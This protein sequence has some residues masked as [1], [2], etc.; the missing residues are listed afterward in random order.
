MRNFAPPFGLGGPKLVQVAGATTL[1]WKSVQA[2]Q[3]T[4]PAG[5]P[6]RKASPVRTIWSRDGKVTP[7]ATSPSVAPRKPAAAAPPPQPAANPADAASAPPAAASSTDETPALPQFKI[8]PREP[9]PSKLG[10][11]VDAIGLA[12]PKADPATDMMAPHA[13]MAPPNAMLPGDAMLPPNAAVA[14]D[15]TAPI[16]VPLPGA[17]GH[18][19]FRQVITVPS[20]V[21]SGG[22]SSGPCRVLAASYGGTKTLLVLLVPGAP[23]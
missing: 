18:V 15:V 8:G 16:D 11:P 23:G 1:P 3:D 22:Q 19:N 13:M 7:I 6:P 14:G 12:T 5:E 4:G 9:S 20:A 21:T 17:A 10:G 2:Q